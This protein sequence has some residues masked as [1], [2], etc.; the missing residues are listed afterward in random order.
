MQTLTH[1]GRSI[2]ELKLGDLSFGQ[3]RMALEEY[4]RLLDRQAPGRLRVLV[5]FEGAHYDSVLSVAWNSRQVL[6]NS[7]VQRSAVIGVSPIIR[8]AIQGYADTADIGEFPQAGRRT[9]VFMA[10][11]QAL[12]WL[13]R[14][15]PERLRLA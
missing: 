11:E 15:H 14:K 7:R 5:D 6:F 2:L 13:T 1:E 4:A 9:M 12:D 10:R 3:S 8:S